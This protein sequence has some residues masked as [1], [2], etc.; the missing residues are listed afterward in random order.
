MLNPISA[1]KAVYKVKIA[2]GHLTYRDEGQGPVIILLHGALINAN[3]WRSV[4][5]PLSKNFRCI[6]PDLPLGGHSHVLGDNADLSPPGIANILDEF[7]QALELNEFVLVGND[8]GGAY[9]QVYTAQYADKVSHLVLSNCDAL[10]VFP[11]KHFSS[12]QKF[13]NVPGYLPAMGALFKIKSFLKSPKVFGLLSHRL[14]GEDIYT[15]FSHNFANDAG[16]RR[17]F[18]KVVNGWSPKHTQA[19]ADHLKHFQK[20]VLLVWGEDDKILFPLSLARRLAAIFPNA[21]LEVV[22]HS[23]TYV[24]EDQPELFVEQLNDFLAV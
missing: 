11:P 17:N 18:R 12:L 13:I 23:L 15:R 8:T 5:G 14:S 20:P 9:A 3:T 24:Q 19:A 4:I 21:R 7:V 22:P 1:G 10:D 16:I 2:S 6:A